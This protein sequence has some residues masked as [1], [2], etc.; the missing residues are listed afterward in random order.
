MAFRSLYSS[1]GLPFVVGIAHLSNFC[2]FVHIQN[3]HD[4]GQGRDQNQ[5]HNH[6]HRYSSHLVLNLDRLRIGGRETF[7]GHSCGKIP[8]CSG[9]L[10]GTQRERVGRMILSTFRVGLLPC[11]IFKPFSEWWVTL[12]F[13]KYLVRWVG[14]GLATIY[15]AVHLIQIF[16]AREQRNGGV[17]RGPRGLKK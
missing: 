5:N 4:V 12:S 15:R 13:I 8:F 14:S 1:T 3:V 10:W 6:I 11:V 9:P 17:P 2:S 7:P 16:L